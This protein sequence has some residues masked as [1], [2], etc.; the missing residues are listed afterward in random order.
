M[1]N[2]DVAALL[3]RVALSDRRAF[4]LLYDSTSAKLYGIVLRILRDRSLAED[5]LQEIYI[6]IWLKASSYVDG[7]QAPMAWLATIARNHAIDV[8][9]GSKRI[10]EDIDEHYDLKSPDKNPEEET[11]LAGERQRIEKCLEALEPQKAEA[12]VSA[13]VEGYSYQELSDRYG[14]P[15]NTMRTWLRRSLASLKECLENG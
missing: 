1:T 14:I 8:I 10:N 5:A 6:R 2:P 7:Q 12:V 13:Y 11:V 4:D 3:A 9:R 15:L